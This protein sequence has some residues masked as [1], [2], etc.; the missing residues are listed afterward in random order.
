T[1]TVPS[2]APDSR[3]RASGE[4]AHTRTGARAGCSSVATAAPVLVLHTIVSASVE[5]DA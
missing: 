3:K 5:Q 1:A 2:N 4:N